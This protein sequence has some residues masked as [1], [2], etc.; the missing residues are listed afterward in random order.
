[1]FMRFRGGG[2]GHNYMQ[3]VE[4]HLNATGWG[5]SWPVLEDRDPEPDEDPTRGDHKDASCD[6]VSAA[7]DVDTRS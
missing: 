1:M 4:P 3:M 5:T 6:A 2:V 7:R